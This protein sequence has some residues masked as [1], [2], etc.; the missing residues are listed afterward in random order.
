MVKAKGESYF[1]RKKNPC[2]NTQLLNVTHGIHIK[3][4]EATGLFEGFPRE[5]VEEYDLALPIDRNKM[6]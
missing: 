2:N 5:W 4:N 3:F 6:V 1:R